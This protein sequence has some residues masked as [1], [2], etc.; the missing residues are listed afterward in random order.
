MPPSLLA[1]SRM[2]ELCQELAIRY[3]DRIMLF[4]S[5]PLLAATEAT[6]DRRGGGQVVLV[7]AENM[8]AR[9]DVRAAVGLLD[10]QKPVNAILNKSRRATSGGYYY[11]GY[12][13]GAHAE[14]TDRPQRCSWIVRGQ[15]YGGR[16]A[17]LAPL[18][19][20]IACERLAQEWVFRA[21]GDT[22]PK[23]GPITSPLRPTGSGNSEWI[24]ELRPGFSLGR[25]ALA[26]RPCSTMTCRRCGSLITATS[27]TFH[28]LNGDGNVA[29]V[30]ESLF[31]DVF[32]RY[33]QQNIDSAG[34]VA[35]SNIFQTGNR[36]DA[37]RLRRQ[38]VPRRSLG[39]LGR[40]PGALPLP[41]ARD[42][43]D[44]RTTPPSMSRTPT[45]TCCPL[46]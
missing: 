12:G 9:E 34:R 42:S 13:Y 14:S 16:Q 19:L 1:S 23:P 18:L 43:R 45:R 8:T 35:Y 46:R 28:Q 10:E 32:A 7:I 41:G 39:Q 30:P 2:R 15:P 17:P 5:P 20:A 44:T 36:T 3:P 38:P 21:A 24:S 37:S 11:G 26:S 25:R 29:V 33:D 31:L 27:T 40:E 4:D 6:G 22:R